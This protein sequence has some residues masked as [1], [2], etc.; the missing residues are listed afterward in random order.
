[1]LDVSE[2]GEVRVVNCRDLLL[3]TQRDGHAHVHNVPVYVDAD[4]PALVHPIL[5]AGIPISSFSV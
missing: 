4:S 2:N 1:M 5:P 3:V